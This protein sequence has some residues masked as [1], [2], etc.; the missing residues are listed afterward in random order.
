MRA[1]DCATS[2]DL[3]G[4][5]AFPP[6]TPL[7]ASLDDN[8]VSTAAHGTSPSDAQANGAGVS[9]ARMTKLGFAATGPALGAAVPSALGAPLG[10]GG[11]GSGGVAAGG[12]GA[13][14]A[15]AWGAR[16]AGV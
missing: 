16:A 6:P 9:F 10:G 13:V 4:T 11:G 8:P 12:T 15:G 3:N 14:P 1:A 2:L 7:Q 5:S